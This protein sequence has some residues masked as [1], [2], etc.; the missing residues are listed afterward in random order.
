[1]ILRWR[2]CTWK[3][4]MRQRGKT[5]FVAVYEVFIKPE[6]RYLIPNGT[7]IV[8]CTTIFTPDI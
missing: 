4:T 6:A 2:A 8:G 5:H 1:M 3:V 7:D